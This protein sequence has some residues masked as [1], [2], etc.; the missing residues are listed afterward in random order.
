MEHIVFV[1]DLFRAL[2]P[3]KAIFGFGV[4]VRRFGIERHHRLCDEK[5][6]DD[7]LGDWS[8]CSHA[9]NMN[10]CGSSANV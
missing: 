4:G 5:L 7:K 10:C 3:A 8:R 2:M 9:N 1:H 6:A